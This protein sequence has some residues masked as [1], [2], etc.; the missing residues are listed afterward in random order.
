MLHALSSPRLRYAALCLLMRV[1][2]CCYDKDVAPIYGDVAVARDM[3]RVGAR[4]RCALCFTRDDAYAPL[5]REA[6]RHAADAL[7]TRDM[8]RRFLFLEIIAMPLIFMLFTD[9]LPSALL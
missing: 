6:R 1:T 2:L 5:P 9:A 3:T 4:T 8:P 7:I